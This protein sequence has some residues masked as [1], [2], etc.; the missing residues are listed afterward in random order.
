MFRR[1]ST[2]SGSVFTFRN[3]S[4]VVGAALLIIIIFLLVMIYLR[5]HDESMPPHERHGIKNMPIWELRE[6]FEAPSVTL[7]VV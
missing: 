2:T 3:I 6:Y 4:I 7:S 5:P 1:D